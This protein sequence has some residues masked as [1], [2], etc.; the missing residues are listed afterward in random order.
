M[1]SILT[2][3]CIL[4]FTSLLFGQN[5]S[6]VLD[7]KKDFRVILNEAEAY[8]EKKHPGIE[9]RSLASGANRDSEYVKFM[10]WK[11]YWENNLNADGSIGDPSLFWRQQNLKTRNANPFSDVQWTNI[12]YQ[13]FLG[14]QIN[15]GRTTSLA[16]HP[17]DSNI[18]YVGAAIGGIWKT[19]D[20]GETYTALGD[21]LPF[22]AVSSIIIN[23]SNPD[24]LFIAISDHLWYGPPAIGVYESTDAGLSWEA[25]SLQ[26]DFQENIRI[27]WMEADPK[28]PQKIF[29]ATADGLFLTTDGFQTVSRIFN[30]PTFDIR[31]QPGNNN[32]LYLGTT[33]G[34]FYRSLDGGASFD[35]IR[36]FGNQAVFLATTPLNPEKVYVRHVK[37]LFKSFDSGSSFTATNTFLEENEVFVIAPNDENIILS[38]NFETSR[39]DQDGLG[40]YKTSQ[41]Y[42]TGDLPLVH[43]D[44]R[45]MFIN[46][47]QNNFVYYCNDGG[48]YRYDVAQ[49]KFTD[50]SNGLAITQYYDIAVS[51]T[52]PNVIGGGSQD[53]GSMYRDANKEW[54][55]YA[56]TGD[57]MNQ[58]IDPTNAN[59]RYWAYQLGELIRWENGSNTPISPPGKSGEGAW[60]TPYRL[61]PNSPQTIIAAYDRVYKSTNSGT[62]WTT[63]SPELANGENLNEIAIAPSNSNRIYVTHNNRLFVKDTADNSWTEKR[64]PATGNISD[65]EVDF[66]DMDILYITN[67]GFSNGNKVFKSEDAGS[68]WTNISGSLP[69]VSTGAIEGYSEKAGALFVGTD[70]GVYYIDSSL[71]DWLEIGA[72]PHTRVEDIEIQYSEHLLRVGTHGRGVFEASILD[73]LNSFCDANSPDS[74]GDDICDLF[75]TCPDFN[76]QL[77]GTPC[78]DGDPFSSDETYFS[79][80]KCEG[81]RANL[82][83]CSAEGSPGTGS[84]YITNIKLHTLNFASE[85]TNYSD[86]R[87]AS[88][89]LEAGVEYRLEMTL[90]YAFPP[91]VAYAWIDYDRNARFDADEQ[92]FMSAFSNNKSTGMVTLPGFIEPGATTMR[93]RVVYNNPDTPPPCG[94]YFGEVEDYTV[95]L[96]NENTTVSTQEDCVDRDKNGICDVQE[97]V[98]IQPNPSRNSFNVQ[99]QKG[100]NIHEIYLLSLDGKMMQS[101]KDLELTHQ[102]EINWEASTAPGLYILYLVTPSGRMAKKVIRI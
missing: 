90:N 96:K 79:T 10:R 74:D 7:Y 57:G 67:P 41:W 70:A 93:V 5:L 102:L 15:M 51:Q 44:Q 43:V 13:E 9:L 56:T 85:Q 54:Y 62:N 11:S 99:W 26:F 29:V 86:F 27:F 84:D 66:E 60:E 38:G 78:D 82:S 68:T 48:V 6:T 69:N 40:F 92:I 55:Y 87:S 80:C 25:T 81:G 46:P 20:G 75:D 35:F 2:F 16:F 52:E 24:H 77:I 19:S 53:N 50:L 23:P 12:S 58:E 89:T 32:I 36:D 22:M 21:D 31:F 91:D 59:K 18:F 17:S 100:R 4:S 73:I 101:F 42:G 30:E 65:I 33:N 3:I 1:K 14:G 83:Y 94:S 71:S 97:E 8:F 37:T 45:N 39:S 28:N 72:L 95:V 47:L 64:L 88:T 98:L 34:S 63:I 76:N 49:N 61:D